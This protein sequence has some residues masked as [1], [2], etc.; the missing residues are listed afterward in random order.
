MTGDGKDTDDLDPQNPVKNK[1]QHKVFH[2]PI[3][4]LATLLGI[5]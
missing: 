5:N 2:S 3:I 4:L 1:R